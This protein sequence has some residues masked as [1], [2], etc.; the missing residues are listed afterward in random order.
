[1]SEQTTEPTEPIIF[2]PEAYF[3]ALLHVLRFASDALAKESWVEVYGWLVGRLEGDSQRVHVYDS[4]PIHHGKDIEVTWDAET[5]V[6]AADFDEQLFE[7]AEKEPDMKGLFIVGWYHSHPGLDFFLSDVDTNNH[8]GFQGPNPQSI[9]IVFDHTKLDLPKGEF[10]FKVFKLKDASKVRDYVEVN[11]EKDAFTKELAD[12]VAL[13]KTTIENVQES[14]LFVTEHNETPSVFSQM[15][16][17]PLSTMP[18]IDKTPPIDLNALF[19]KLITSTQ[20][21]IQ[22]A[23]GDSIFGKLAADIAPA[24]DEWYSAFVPYLVTALDKWMLTLSDKVVT[25]NK[26]TYNSIYQVAGI[27]EKSMKNIT[28]WTK[29]QV[30]ESK[31]IVKKTLDEQNAK[32]LQSVQESLEAQQAAINE[33]LSHTLQDIATRMDHVEARVGEEVDKGA[34]LAEKIDAMQASIAEIMETVGQRLDRIQD[35]VNENLDEKLGGVGDQVASTLSGIDAK[36]QESI[37]R[38]VQDLGAALEDTKTQLQSELQAISQALAKE[39]QDLDELA[40][41][42]T[43]KKMQDDMQKIAKA[44]EKAKQ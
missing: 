37:E 22:R 1:M 34:K 15:L 3:K 29:V 44:Q 36:M 26:L 30:S 14:Q 2:E 6:R 33:I 7:K 32:L 23:F 38:S 19:E 43:I 20:A 11:I 8:L 39:K 10:G 24:I 16:Y 13:A 5:Y 18:A 40:A 41:T 25:S 17:P 9:A 31:R 12:I 28:D 21:L 35:E 4:V 27:L 42:K